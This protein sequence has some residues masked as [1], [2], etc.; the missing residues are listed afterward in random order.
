MAR[1]RR[2]SRR[3]ARWKYRVPDGRRRDAPSWPRPDGSRT[4]RV[5]S[6][7]ASS[8]ESCS[9]LA[10]RG[11]IFHASSRRRGC[12]EQWIQ[13]A[14]GGGRGDGRRAVFPDPRPD[15]AGPAF[16]SDTAPGC[17]NGCLSFAAS[18][19][20]T[21]IVH[22]TR[23]AD[24]P[25]PTHPGSSTGPWPASACSLR[26]APRG[27]PGSPDRT[28]FELGGPGTIGAHAALARLSSSFG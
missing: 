26:F 23:R 14:V 11:S 18:R 3:L 16:R 7:R 9:R 8:H 17:V 5:S 24:L 2:R 10:A 12:S 27:I 4:V 1:G 21:S 28:H 6:R 19:M 13:L 22:G 25:P 20:L 15:P